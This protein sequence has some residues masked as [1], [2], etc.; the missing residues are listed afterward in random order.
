MDLLSWWS[1]RLIRAKYEKYLNSEHLF[2][3]T[4]KVG[5]D[6][7]EIDGHKF[8]FE[9]AS[10]YFMGHF[11]HEWKDKDEIILEEDDY[12]VILYNFSFIYTGCTELDMKTCLRYFKSPTNSCWQTSFQV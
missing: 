8:L 3:V 11:Y 12:E 6:S 5:K 2:D 7:K 10:D 4:F 1:S 9:T